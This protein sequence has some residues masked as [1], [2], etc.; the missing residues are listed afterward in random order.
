MATFDKCS[1]QI[2]K[3]SHYQMQQVINVFPLWRPEALLLSLAQP[4]PSLPHHHPGF[5]SLFGIPGLSL[6][7]WSAVPRICGFTFLCFW[8]GLTFSQG[9]LTKDGWDHLVLSLSFFLVVVVSN[10]YDFSLW[11]CFTFSILFTFLFLEVL[12]G[13][14]SNMFSKQTLTHASYFQIVLEKQ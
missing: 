8:K 4:Q 13:S 5:L 6:F 11:L 7:V 1:N 12:F 2:L 14:F 3:P 9:A 10:S